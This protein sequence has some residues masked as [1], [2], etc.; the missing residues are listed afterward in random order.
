MENTKDRFYVDLQN[1]T[2]EW[3]YY[4]PDSDSGGQFVLCKV[5]Y[6]D[7]YEG[8]KEKTNPE[9]LFSYLESICRQV[10]YDDKDGVHDPEGVALYERDYVCEGI[11]YDTVSE[12]DYLHRAKF[13]INSYC[14]QE[15]GYKADFEDLKRIGLA[16]T[17]TETGDHDIQAYADLRNH[18]IFTELDSKVVVTNQ[19]KSLSEMFHKGL[20]NLSFDELVSVPEVYEK[21]IIDTH[22]LAE[23]MVYF[24]KD[25][26]YY[27]YMDALNNDETDADAIES[28]FDQLTNPDTFEGLYSNMLELLED[29]HMEITYKAR[30]YPILE[31]MNLLHNEYGIPVCDNEPA[32]LSEVF[33]LLGIKEYGISF[34]RD[35]ICITLDGKNYYNEDFYK[36]FSKEYLTPKL[37]NQLREKDF[38]VYADYKE[39]SSVKGYDIPDPSKRSR[40][41]RER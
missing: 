18:E 20:E 26:D 33:R 22:D 2:I 23:R 36:C 13:E 27:D 29:D 24:M 16:Y 15:F 37:T 21:K 41:E 35:G 40:K 4:N 31:E 3:M 9:D 7:F 8:L 38:Q 17:T 25:Y 34:D 10:L 5:S 14:M 6:K 1:D 30:L 32:I 19:Y 11:S 39:L 28:T 12:L